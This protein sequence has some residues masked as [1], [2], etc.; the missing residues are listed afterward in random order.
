MALIK[1]HECSGQVSDQARTCPHCGALLKRAKAAPKRVSQHPTGSRAA[2][3][4]RYFQ[5]LIE[6]QRQHGHVTVPSHGAGRGLFQWVSKQRMLKR[7]NRLRPDR[8]Q[9]LERLGFNWTYH[10]PKLEQA[11]E[12]RLAEL[13]E[14]HRLHGHF[15]VPARDGHKQLYVWVNQQ[16][17][18]RHFGLIRADRQQRLE[19]V[20]FVWHNAMSRWELTWN[21]NFDRIIAFYQ[22]HGHFHIP[23]GA[24]S[25]NLYIWANN[26]RLLKRFNRLRP[27][28]QQR[29]AAAGFTWE[30]PRHRN[31]AKQL[32]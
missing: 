13:V 18:A 19:A 22:T 30:T 14:F 21:E 28:R 15:N 23:A 4:A 7:F 9:Q 29:L 31:R 32:A 10:S 3:W 12:R 26:Q 11:W 1:C 24:A 20:G 6:F 5:E 16:R 8:Q 2:R 25:Y 27:D 17:Y